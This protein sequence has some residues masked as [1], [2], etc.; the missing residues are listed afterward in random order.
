M[1]PQLAQFAVRQARNVAKNILRKE[2][3]EEMRELEYL[4]KGQIISL[5]TNCIGTLNGFPISGWLCENTED[6]V[7]DNY[8]KAVLNRG[9]GLEAMVYDRNSIG[10]EIVTSINFISYICRRLMIPTSL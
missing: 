8:I 10:I 4:Q 7:I 2:C 1:S 9:E 3:G 5:G 6:F